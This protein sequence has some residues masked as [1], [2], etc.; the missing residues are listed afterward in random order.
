ML[1]KCRPI[2]LAELGYIGDQPGHAI[3]KH[4]GA[5]GHRHYGS[6]AP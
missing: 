3:A 4:N 5:N 2:I 6:R 1:D